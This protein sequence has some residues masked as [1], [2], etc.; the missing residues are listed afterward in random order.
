MRCHLKS[1]QFKNM[2]EEIVEHDKLNDAP[3]SRGTDFMQ[4]ASSG[5]LIN[6]AVRLILLHQGSRKI[7][8]LSQNRIF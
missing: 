3:L 8:T 1:I 6:F 2:D 4:S 7:A 5:I